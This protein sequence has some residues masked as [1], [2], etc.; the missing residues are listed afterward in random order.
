MLTRT[1]VV[2]DSNIWISE[3]GLRSALGS[4]TRMFLIGAT[5]RVLLLT[6]G[7][8]PPLALLRSFRRTTLCLPRVAPLMLIPTAAAP[9]R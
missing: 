2:L 8:V 1:Y 5:L 4:A 9:T 7:W 6:V 3:L